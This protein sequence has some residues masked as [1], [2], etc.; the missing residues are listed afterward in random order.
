MAFRF[1]RSARLGPLRFNFTSQGLSS[2]SLG[3]PGVSLNLPIH[4]R[5]GPRTTLGLPGTG[6]SWTMEAPPAGAS[7]K[8]RSDPPSITSTTTVPWPAGEA[9]GLPNSR[10][11]RSSQLESFRMSCLQMLRQRLFA[12]GAPG[13]LLWDQDLV[14]RLLKDADLGARSASQL[15]A[16]A[17]PA[18]LDDYVGR[19][20][21]QDEVKRRCQRCID[22]VSMA[23]ALVAQRRWS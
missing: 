11:L 12:E 10:R 9:A 7:A 21:S 4:R 20:R 18:A 23:L 8:A 6:L 1:R 2:I 19:A 5:G 3:A 14:N 22:A 15:A 13:H 17:S 16:I